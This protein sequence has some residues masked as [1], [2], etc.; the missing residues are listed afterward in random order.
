MF[1]KSNKNKGTIIV[2]FL[3]LITIMM[4]M[5]AFSIDVGYV[6]A[7]KAELQHAADSAAMAAIW[8]MKDRNDPYLVSNAKAKAI[9]FG[10]FNKAAEVGALT[11]SEDDVALGFMD[12]PFNINKELD[13]YGMEMNTVEVCVKR[14]QEL[15]GTLGLFMGNFTGTDQVQLQ[16]KARAF[17]TDRI[18]GFDSAPGANPVYSEGGGGLEGGDG[19]QSNSKSIILWP[20]T[21]NYFY[22]EAYWRAFKGE[23][24]PIYSAYHPCMYIDADR[25]GLADDLDEDGVGNIKPEDEDEEIIIDP[26][27]LI[28]LTDEYSYH[29]GALDSLSGDYQVRSD[30]MF[31]PEFEM[32]PIGVDA[33]GNFGTIDIG[34]TNNSADDL[35]RQIAEGV[36]TEDIQ[37]ADS[38][39]NGHTGF[40]LTEGVIDLETGNIL[41]ET[42][43]FPNEM[44]TENMT[45]Y[46]LIDG[47]TGLSWSLKNAILGQGEFSE[48]LRGTT[49][50]LPLFYKSY[51]QQDLDS[52]VINYDLDPLKPATGENTVFQLVS[53][54]TVRIID[55][56]QGGDKGIRV[57]PTDYPEFALPG[58]E[59]SGD[60]QYSAMGYDVSSSAIIGFDGPVIPS[61]SMFVYGLTR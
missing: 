46:K 10:G 41:S 25:N 21:V 55:V 42:F 5:L 34:K 47:D 19:G 57:E 22:W 24:N 35:K 36:T 59:G 26:D 60:S 20:F 8:E 61:S 11:V 30:G 15:N 53:W 44:P 9:E 39:Y 23:N 6:Y 2:M 1:Q 18:I 33:S 32:Y 50:I 12:D 29:D 27:D 17:I 7:T 48:D 13:P 31:I 54:C 37:L 56:I 28:P 3:V 43:E 58:G 45:G 38:Q 51:N 16:A 49:V 40:F 14:T 4:F 52:G